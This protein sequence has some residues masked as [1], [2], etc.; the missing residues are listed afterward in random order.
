[1]ESF[2]HLYTAQDLADFIASTY[3]PERQLAELE[4]PDSA[5]WLA[6]HAGQPVG[7]VKLGPCKLPLPSHLA[8]GPSSEVLEIHRLYVRHAHQGQGHGPRLLE[9]ALAEALARKVK[10]LYLG[11]WENNA[12]AQAL[13][14]R[15]GFEP[16]GHYFFAVGSQRDHEII[17]QRRL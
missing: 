13:Y 12:R 11:V 7:Y 2:G 5:L 10:N 4:C 16:V 3:T 17:M 1:I 8:A 6:E 15:Y 9:T 14:R